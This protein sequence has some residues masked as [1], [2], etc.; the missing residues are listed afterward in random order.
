[1]G[2]D[3][4]WK[5]AEI[6]SQDFNHH[7]PDRRHHFARMHRAKLQQSLLHNLS[8]DILHL[9]KKAISAE[10]STTGARVVFEDGTSITAD[11]VIGADGI[12]SV[13]VNRRTPIL[14]CEI[15]KKSKVKKRREGKPDLPL[16][17]EN[18]KLFHP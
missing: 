1:M 13:S 17:T 10:V 4:H 16:P 5:T 9:G 15:L 14:I 3:R 12:K 2:S 6:L 18:T 11:V 8:P 7:V